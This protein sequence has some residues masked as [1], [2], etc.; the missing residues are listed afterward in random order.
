MALTNLL[1][2]I[3]S[4]AVAKDRTLAEEA[5]RSKTTARGPSLSA[6]V[7]IALGGKRRLVREKRL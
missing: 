6:W 4:R 1:V 3:W 7:V 2:S 5:M